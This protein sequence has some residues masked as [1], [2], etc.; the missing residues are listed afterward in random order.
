MTDPQATRPRAVLVAG[1]ANIDLVLRGDVVPRFGQV[2]QMLDAADLV[3]GGSASIVAC[4]LARLGVPTTLAARVGADVL[5]AFT[6][7]ALRSA[8]VDT[9]SVEVDAHVPTGMSV[10]LSAPGDRAILTNP[11]TIP[12]LGGEQV[13]AAATRVQAAH[14]HVASFF[15]QPG[16]AAELPSVLADAHARGMTTSL[17]TNWDPSERWDGLAEVLVHVDLLM[18]NLEEL[19]ALARALGADLPAGAGPGA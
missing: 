9:A 11:G 10:I 18:P 3:L 4:G 8:G 12:T 17:D 15:L 5:G 7:D 2:E 6:L 1:D 19:R 13:L 16:L 14:L